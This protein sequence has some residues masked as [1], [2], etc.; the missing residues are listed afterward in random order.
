MISMGANSKGLALLLIMVIALSSPLIV[1][2]SRAQSLTEPSA[3][4]FT[5]KIVDYM[6]GGGLE[7]E[8]QNQPIIQN[9]HDTAGIF[10]D[11]RYKWHESSS[12]YHPEP[13]PTKWER[14]YIAEIGTTG[15]TT[16]VDSPSSYYKILGSSNGHQLD[17]QVRTING[18]SNTSVPFVPPIGIEP[19]AA[20]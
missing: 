15:V 20:Q 18:Y 11:F 1:Q 16:L 13:D 7:I 6:V 14:Q 4:N 9:G 17:Y 2:S 12:W 8:I 19:G 10:F 3:P 5:L